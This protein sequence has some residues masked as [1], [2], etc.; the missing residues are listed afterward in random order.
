MT[1][2]NIKITNHMLNQ[3]YEL[4]SSDDIQH[5][6]K[7]ERFMTGETTTFAEFVVNRQKIDKPKAWW[8]KW[9]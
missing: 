1:K 3:Y 4:Y 5:S 6:L 2:V 9:F 7:V 8:R